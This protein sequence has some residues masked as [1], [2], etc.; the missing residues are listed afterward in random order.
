[1]TM[2]ERRRGLESFALAVK[3]SGLEVTP[4]TSGHSPLTHC[5]IQPQGARKCNLS[6]YSER[7]KLEIFGEQY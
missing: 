2:T 1:M 3:C 7:R 5:S 6:V 4:I